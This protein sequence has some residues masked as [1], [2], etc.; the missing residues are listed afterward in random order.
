MAQKKEDL[1][2]AL[3][4]T[5]QHAV[6]RFVNAVATPAAH[7]LGCVGAAFPV[8]VIALVAGQAHRAFLFDGQVAA[9][10][11]IHAGDFASNQEQQC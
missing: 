1:P 7:I 2:P 9:R 5:I 10:V 6:M 4:Q 3:G 8:H 11:E